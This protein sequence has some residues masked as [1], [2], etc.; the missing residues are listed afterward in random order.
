MSDC[1]D[2]T[3]KS[4]MIKF[5]FNFNRFWVLKS[6]FVNLNQLLLFL[7]V[8]FLSEAKGLVEGHSTNTETNVKLQAQLRWRTIGIYLKTILHKCY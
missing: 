5:N 7:L 3:E 2:L 1:I 6:H 4:C 8:V